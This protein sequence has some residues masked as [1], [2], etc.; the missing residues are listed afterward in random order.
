MEYKGE[1]GSRKDWRIP[2]LTV[3]GT[4]QKITQGCDKQY[5]GSDRFTFQS[6]PIMCAS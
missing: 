1:I 3:Y 5:G 2:T 4:V 6:V